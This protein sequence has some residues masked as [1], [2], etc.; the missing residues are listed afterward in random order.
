MAKILAAGHLRFFIPLLLARFLPAHLHPCP[1]SSYSI[2]TG[3]ISEKPVPNWSV[4]ASYAGGHHAMVRNLA[5]D[6]KPIRVNGVS[7]GIVDTELWQLSDEARG[8]FMAERGGE[9]ATG[10]AGRVEDVV[11]SYLA[12]LRDENMDG[13]VVRTDG[14]GLVM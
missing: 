4:I 1:R 5:R 8:K 9:L 2:T 11:E 14:G 12:L 7:P 13:S 6:L 3:L 10:R